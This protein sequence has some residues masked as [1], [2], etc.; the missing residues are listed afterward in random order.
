M[1]SQLRVLRCSI[2]PLCLCMW[3]WVKPH[4]NHCPIYFKFSS[5]RTHTHTNIMTLTAHKRANQTTAEN[6]TWLRGK[7][8]DLCNH[9]LLF[10]LTAGKHS[11]KWLSHTLSWF[12]FGSFEPDTL[13]QVNWSWTY[14]FGCDNIPENSWVIIC[15]LLSI[16]K[17]QLFCS[18][19]GMMAQPPMIKHVS[20]LEAYGGSLYLLTEW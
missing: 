16:I 8:Q 10:R 6:L 14:S 20:N 12:L 18:Q 9:V 5:N 7:C 19:R 2:C 13:V 4:P 1:P 17:R 3:W 15:S 11:V